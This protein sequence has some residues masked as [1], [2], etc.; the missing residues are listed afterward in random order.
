MREANQLEARVTLGIGVMIVALGTLCIVGAKFG[1]TSTVAMFHPPENFSPEIWDNVHPARRL[2][3]IP[4][5]DPAMPGRVLDAWAT[6]HAPL[7]TLSDP[8]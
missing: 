4:E 8:R 3:V 6:A 5:P 2:I 7:V 1:H